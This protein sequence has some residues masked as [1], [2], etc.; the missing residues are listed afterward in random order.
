[1]EYTFT[2][3]VL[4]FPGA[5]M[6]WHAGKDVLHLMAMDILLR[7]VAPEMVWM[8]QAIYLVLILVNIMPM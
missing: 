5:L 1:M 8:D 2:S 4:L 7:F 3:F 6:F